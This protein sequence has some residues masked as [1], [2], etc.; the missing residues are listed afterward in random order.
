MALEN[1][2]F[3][4]SLKGVIEFDCVELARKGVLGSSHPLGYGFLMLHHCSS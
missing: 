1:Q 4:P 2:L 3:T